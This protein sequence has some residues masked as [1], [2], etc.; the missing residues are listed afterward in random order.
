[1]GQS[2]NACCFS[3]GEMEFGYPWL[4]G[5]YNISFILVVFMLSLHLVAHSHTFLSAFSIILLIAAENILDI[6]TTQSSS[7]D[8]IFIPLMS[9]IRRTSSVTINQSIGEIA[10]PWEVPLP[11]VW[12]TY[13][14]RLNY[15]SSEGEYCQLPKTR[16]QCYSG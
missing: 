11:T 14:I 3:R 7:Y 15:P 12:C 10:P 1:M 4:S 9:S 6:K 5:N 8:T 16:F 2:A 13:Q